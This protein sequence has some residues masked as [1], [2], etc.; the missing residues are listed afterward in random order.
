[1]LTYDF[2][3]DTRTSAELVLNWEKKQF[4]VKVEFDVDK[5]VMEN[6]AK[7]LKG[8]TGFAWQSYV[9]AVNYAVQNKVNYDEALT[10]ADRAVLFNN[11]FV[12][13][14]T[15]ANLQRAMGKTD[16]ADKTM[17]GALAIAN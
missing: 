13:L 2:M 16:D 11:S 14:S 9:S 4:P 5:I 15:K 12:T 8:Q 17:A 3:N 6:A 10:W 1:M 7:E